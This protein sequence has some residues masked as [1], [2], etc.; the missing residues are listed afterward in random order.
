MFWRKYNY[1]F[2]NRRYWIDSQELY[3]YFSS[4]KDS[5]KL[6]D[7]GEVELNLLKIDY[8]TIAK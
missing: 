8:S 7:V 3:E 4:N 2:T 5:F 1:S 6:N